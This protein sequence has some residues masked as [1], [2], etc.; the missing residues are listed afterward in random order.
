MRP[1]NIIAQSLRSL[2]TTGIATELGS[3]DVAFLPLAAGSV[4]PF[5]EKLLHI[6][7]DHEKL[8]SSIHC[9]PRDA[10]EIHRSMRAKRSVGI[11]WGTFTTALHAA[12]TVAE[13]A[14]SNASHLL[15]EKSESHGTELGVEVVDVGSVQRLV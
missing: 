15:E 14:K 4:L 1:A 3:P 5:L 13:V 12:Q 10:V 6:R 2:T 11:H 7:L 8:T 9:T